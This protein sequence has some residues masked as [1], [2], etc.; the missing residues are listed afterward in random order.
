MVRLERFELSTSCFGGTR[1]IHLSY[2]RAGD[3]L[4]VP[5]RQCAKACAIATVH[6]THAFIYIMG[7]GVRLWLAFADPAL[8]GMAIS[9]VNEDGSSRTGTIARSCYLG[10]THPDRQECLSYSMRS[11]MTEWPLTTMSIE[12]GGLRPEP[13]TISPRAHVLPPSGPIFRG[14]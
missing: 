3:L 14:S 11:A 2:S 1:S 6:R 12:S 10:M 4:R 8:A 9:I 7:S 13:C 5:S